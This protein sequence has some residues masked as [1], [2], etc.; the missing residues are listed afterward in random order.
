VFYWLVHSAI[1]LSLFLAF[2]AFN[3]R[4]IYQANINERAL[5][6]K[7]GWSPPPQHTIDDIV[8]LPPSWRF[9]DFAY[10]AVPAHAILLHWIGILVLWPWLTTLVLMVYRISMRQAKLRPIHVLRC[11]IYSTATT[12]LLAG[13]L[14]FAVLM[15]A[16]WMFP[17]YW[18]VEHE[19][20]AGKLGIAAIWV[21]LAY[22]LARAYRHYLRFKQATLAV[23]LSQIIVVLVFAQL[24]TV[25]FGFEDLKQ[26]VLM[27]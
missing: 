15:L 12:A 10:T 22:R 1:L 5:L 23:V 16:M 4:E 24:M 26:L 13:A 2:Y 14:T 9:F 11:T 18:T 6:Q 17:Q 27:R 25:F 8:P 3:C 21:A 19:D 7:N 20:L